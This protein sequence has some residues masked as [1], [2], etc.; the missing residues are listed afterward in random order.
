MK[1]EEKEIIDLADSVIK[2]NNFKENVKETYGVVIFDSGDLV[3]VFD[4]FE[5]I[6]EIWKLYKLALSLEDKLTI[7]TLMTETTS[8]GV[9]DIGLTVIDITKVI[10]MYPAYRFYADSENKQIANIKKARAI[11]RF[12]YEIQEQEEE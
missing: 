12:L 11:D 3:K 8:G 2:K 6:L 7:K 1:E 9:I 4:N 5:I 10:S